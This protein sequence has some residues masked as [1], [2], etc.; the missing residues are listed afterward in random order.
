MDYISIEIKSRFKSGAHKRHKML[1][2][3][4]NSKY[5]SELLKIPF[6]NVYFKKFKISNTDKD[7]AYLIIF[8]YKY[9]FL[10]LLLFF[11][12]KKIDIFCF[13][14]CD[15][16]IYKKY[17]NPTLKEKL[18]I[19]LSKFILNMNLIKVFAIAQS[20]GDAKSI[21]KFYK[22]IKT[23]EI[24]PNNINIKEFKPYAWISKTRTKLIRIKKYD[25]LFIGG[26]KNIRKNFSLIKRYILNI[27]KMA[28]KDK[29]ESI[30]LVG[31]YEN[32]QIEV[33]KNILKKFNIKLI[34]I[35][36]FKKISEVRK[37]NTVLLHPSMADSFPNLILECIEEYIPFV[38]SNIYISKLIIKDNNLLFNPQSL[39][40]LDKSIIYLFDLI[41]SDKE[42]NIF[43]EYSKNLSFDWNKRV[44]KS[45]KNHTKIVSE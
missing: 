7:K 10:S 8:G 22:G 15:P 21:I 13:L 26:S 33:L 6:F 31:E 39:D 14:R 27:G 37:D 29:L 35:K 17:T 20:S 1:F 11:Y 19:S 41:K 38:L 36:S 4:L 40:S 28:S 18:A 30:T 34:W 16:I 2:D 25:L 45:L 42:I 23:C 5:K 43:T 32:N 9:I 24:I 12:Y 3:Y 44:L